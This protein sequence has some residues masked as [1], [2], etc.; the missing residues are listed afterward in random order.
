M[1]EVAIPLGGKKKKAFVVPEKKK[2]EG[3]GVAASE[4]SE[5]QAVV[6]DGDGKAA[7]KGAKGA[8]G[9][10][11]K[12]VKEDAPEV[13]KDK[14]AESEKENPKK[15]SDKKT[16][17]STSADKGKPKEK[18][19]PKITQSSNQRTLVSE[20]SDKK[21]PKKGVVISIE[22][23]EVKQK[24]AAKQDEKKSIVEEI[25]ETEKTTNN[26]DKKPEIA[27]KKFVAPPVVEKKTIEPEK[28][29]KSTDKQQKS[30][31]V[32]STSSARAIEAE[33]PKDSKKD[34]KSNKG[35]KKAKKM[36]RIEVEEE[37]MGD[38]DSEDEDDDK[39]VLDSDESQAS[40][41]ES[42]ENSNKKGTLPISLHLR[43]NRQNAI[44]KYN[45]RKNIGEKKTSSLLNPLDIEASDDDKKEVSN[46]ADGT[47]GEKGKRH[48]ATV[49]PI[50]AFSGFNT[51]DKLIMTNICK[52]LKA[53]VE[54][55]DVFKFTLL[56]LKDG[57]RTKKVI[58]ALVRGSLYLTKACQLLQPTTSMH[59]SIN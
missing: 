24:S 39:F 8:G 23:K 47:I 25:V 31:S 52:K 34:K 57:T 54:D 51:D 16:V 15:A 44:H 45:F 26:A 11:S 5:V 27:K 49:K 59:L 30:K 53:T 20:V 50:V 55:N 36:K 2:T 10:K 1:E 21:D 35:E 43:K 17:E 41:I 4:V 56:I 9:K 19:S 14:V 3:D 38:E 28:P 58:F 37:V 13:K 12:G 32:A 40:G 42:Q 33:K 7:G 46:A 48:S 29:A 22:E 6:V 18:S